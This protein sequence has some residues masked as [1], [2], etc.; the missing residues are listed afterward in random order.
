[1]M[2]DITKSR[3]W[4]QLSEHYKQIA[5]IHMRDL[6]RDD[7]E[8]FNKFSI[9][10]RNRHACSLPVLDYSKNRIT[11]E[12]INLLCELAKTADL[13]SHIEQMFSGKII[14]TTEQRAVLHTALRNSGDTA[15]LLNGKDIMPTIR[16][17][18]TK[19]LQCAEN[20]KHGKWKGYSGKSITD[21]VNIGI[22]GS[23]LGPRMAV[24]ALTPYISNNIKCHFV[25][26][27]DGTHISETLKYL[28]PETTLFIIA[29]KTFTTQETLCNANT[30]KEWLEQ[31]ANSKNANKMHLIAVTANPQR[32]IEFG[33]NKN[34]IYPFWD[35]VGGRYSLWSAIG[36]PIAIAIGAENFQQLL[37]GAHAMDNHFRNTPFEKN[38]PVIM[39]LLGIWNIN[40]FNCKTHAIIPYDQYLHFLP[41]YLQQLEMESNGKHV[42]MDGSSV[43]YATAPVIWG[44]VGSN[45]QHAFHQ[46]L[47]QGTQTVP[48]DFII[49]IHTHNPIGQHHMLLFA[50]C[51][52][53]SKALMQG[54]TEQQ[55]IQEL[56]DQG[57]NET[58]AKKLATHK[59]IFG[60][61][62]S[63][64]ILIDK[65]TP[66]TL[67]TLIALYEHKVFAQGIIWGIN[68]FDQWGVEL[69]KQ[70]TKNII[71]SLQDPKIIKNLDSS[72]CG[73]IKYYHSK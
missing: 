47:L 24:S 54:K 39:A 59:V 53:Q 14:N 58:N 67:G 9:A 44:S 30:A 63:N 4:Q 26:N 17:T 25:S 20:I 49:P 31:K 22:G 51:L 62:P 3:I 68:S 70:L 48:V 41:A 2:N 61:V 12:T 32:A 55:A 19:M 56:I 21:V 65:I 1:M 10:I 71:P 5:N 57:M 28:N 52:A 11:S 50:N 13:S 40:F 37:A 7:Q 16:V 18:L 29:S 8:R 36:L 46:L 66:Y 42:H 34:N 33:I 69:S 35:W 38:M 45:G 6:F 60:N 64:T 23:D 43:E 72:T 73:L 27:V 15:I